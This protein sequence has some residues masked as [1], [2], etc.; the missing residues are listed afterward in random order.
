VPRPARADPARILHVSQRSLRV[1]GGPL[2]RLLR[3][4]K[5]RRGARGRTGNNSGFMGAYRY[6]LIR[7][8]KESTK[9]GQDL[10]IL[11]KT[12]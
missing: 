9:T 7:L 8:R 3:P 10:P 6:F 4:H 2:A 12:T 5:G 1:R 11:Q